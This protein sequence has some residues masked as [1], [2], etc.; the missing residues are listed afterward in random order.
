MCEKFQQYALAEGALVRHLHVAL[1]TQ[2]TDNRLLTHR[3]VRVYTQSTLLLIQLPHV[4]APRS[5]PPPPPRPAP[6]AVC[7]CVRVRACVRVQA[8]EPAPCWAVDRQSPDLR[9]PLQAHLCPF[10]CAQLDRSQNSPRSPNLIEI[11]VFFKLCEVDS[12]DG[13]RGC[14]LLAVALNPV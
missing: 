10:L 1:Y 4:H 3:S 2:S 14:E 12:L 11:P 5:T 6:I 8:A 7:A 9:R 13:L